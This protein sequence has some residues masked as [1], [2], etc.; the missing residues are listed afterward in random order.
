MKLFEH[1]VKSG[2]FCQRQINHLDKFLN[3]GNYEEILYMY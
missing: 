3:I 2:Y 1:T